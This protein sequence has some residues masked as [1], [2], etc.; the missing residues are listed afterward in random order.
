MSLSTWIYDNKLVIDGAGVV[1]CDECPCETGTGTGTGT[2]YGVCNACLN[3]IMPT[4]IEVTFPSAFSNNL[5][6]NCGLYG[7]STLVLSYDGDTSCSWSE[8]W[9]DLIG[10][11][12]CIMGVLSVAVSWTPGIPE[13]K[14]RLLNTAQPWDIWKYTQ[15]TK[16][17]CANMD[18]TLNFVLPQSS[19]ACGFPLTVNVKAR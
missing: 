6:A 8:K 14:I 13:G 5:C 17:D 3:D 9:S 7:A 15:A 1:L 2:E 11:D 4:E 19:F 10:S 16:I 12:P 18:L